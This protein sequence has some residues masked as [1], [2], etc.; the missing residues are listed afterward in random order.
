MAS[1]AMNIERY[2]NDRFA[3]NLRV[4]VV[5]CDKTVSGVRER[6]TTRRASH[7][8]NHESMMLVKLVSCMYKPTCN[9]KSVD[10]SLIRGVWDFGVQFQFV[11]VV[12][13]N[14]SAFG[15]FE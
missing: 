10:L 3:K 2:E 14:V 15:F 13:C 9:P 12:T 11:N 6:R 8:M 5:G 7:L 1:V 4:G